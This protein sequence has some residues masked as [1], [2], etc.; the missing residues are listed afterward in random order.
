[1]ILSRSTRILALFAIMAFAAALRVPGIYWGDGEIGKNSFA[2]WHVDEDTHVE[3]AKQFLSGKVDYGFDY[4]KGFGAHIAAAANLVKLFGW[5]TSA[6]DLHRFGRWISLCYGLGT[7]LLVH[8]AVSRISGS[9]AAALLAAWF[10]AVCSLAVTNSHFAA[11]D[12]AA[13][14][15]MWAAAYLC[16]KGLRDESSAAKLGAWASCGMALAVKITVAACFPLII[17]FL[18]GKNRWRILF[19]GM[20]ISSFVFF[21]ANGWGVGWDGMLA[22]AGKILGDSVSV[23]PRHSA[24]ETAFTVFISLFPAY[25]LPLVLLAVIGLGEARR[26]IANVH[27][28]YWGCFAAPAL[29]HAFLVLS[30]DD[31][32]ERHLLPF[33]PAICGLAAMGWPKVFPGE[34]HWSFQALGP[35]ALVS[36]LVFFA[37]DG[38]YPFWHDNRI[39]ARSWI[40]REVEPGS[41]MLEGPYARLYLPNGKYKTKETGLRSKTFPRIGDFDFLALHEFHTYRYERSRLSPFRKPLPGNIYHPDRFGLEYWDG[42]KNGEG[43]L[44]LIR[45][46]PAPGQWSPERR[47]YK[48]YWGTFT[49]FVGDVY[50]FKQ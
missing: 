49:S 17:L 4:V 25:S 5:K 40:V 22:I 21:A 6:E 42:L 29:G 39:T 7:I 43:P 11:A 34:G 20:S 47:F 19:A 45:R 12:S 38:E 50:I 16:W 24:T 41:R 23:I 30:L 31:P 10:M 27:W 2:H 28:G 9:R 1:M 26:S 48:K 15:W 44:K 36:Y 33:A 46:F 32:F 18:A 13:C 8:I 14:F 3:I 35:L 37:I